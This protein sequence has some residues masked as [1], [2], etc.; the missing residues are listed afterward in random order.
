MGTADLVAVFSIPILILWVVH[1]RV[2]KK[3]KAERAAMFDQCLNLFDSYRVTQDDVYYPVL[4]G[5]YKGHDVKLEPISDDIGFRTLPSLWLLVTFRGN[6][7]YDGLFDFLVRP[8]NSVE[9]YSPSSELGTSI[10]IPQGWPTH[11]LLRTNDR[12]N[13]PPMEKLSPHIDMFNDEKMKEL[14]VG[15]GGV[16]VVYQIDKA[17]L[18]YYKLLRQV[19]FEHISP[20]PEVVR[21]LLDKAHAIYR[22]LAEDGAGIGETAKTAK[23]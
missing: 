19:R 11:A 5:R 6:I 16:R 23:I 21:G 10:K 3:V 14:F 2:K 18:P 7:P 9:F 15:P 8:K 13:M 20:Q 4:E 12:W 22:D 1:Y 17:L